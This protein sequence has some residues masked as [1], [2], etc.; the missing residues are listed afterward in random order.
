[1]LCVAIMLTASFFTL[2][3]VFYIENSDFS[4]RTDNLRFTDY[5][6]KIG[7][8]VKELQPAFYI[9]YDYQEAAEETHQLNCDSFIFEA[10]VRVGLLSYAKLSTEC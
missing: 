8:V 4:I 1:M 6:V 7:E 2:K 5:N 3:S 10:K 9:A